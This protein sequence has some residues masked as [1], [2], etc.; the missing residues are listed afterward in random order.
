MDL[1]AP[2]TG[3][4]EFDAVVGA[5]P[6]LIELR[7]DL[8]DRDDHAALAARCASLPVPLI[9]TVRSTRRGRRVRRRRGRLR[10]A[11]RPVRA[12]CPVRRPRAPVPGPR[13]RL[14]RG[15]A[16]PSSPRPTSRPCSRSPSSSGS[17]GSSGRTATSPSSVLAPSSDDDLLDLLSFTHAATKP[18]CTSIA[19]IRVPPRPGPAAPLRLGPRLLRGR[20]VVLARAV[21]ARRDARADAP[22]PAGDRLTTAR[23]RIRRPPA[24]AGR[25][26]ARARAWPRPPGRAGARCRGRAGRRHGSRPAGPR[27]RPSAGGARSTAS[28]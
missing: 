3:L 16:V 20:P 11:P 10:P 28:A 18:V 19:G 4:D 7:L 13:P 9:A 15:R 22:A 14:P 25:P 12:A 24:R 23:R 27:R 8:V 21:H 17:S 6:D 1:V 5:G 26:R 2:V